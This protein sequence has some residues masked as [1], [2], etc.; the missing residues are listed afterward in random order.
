MRQAI[1]DYLFANKASLKGLTLSDNL[2]WVD[3]TAPLYLQNKKY[4]YVDVDQV[5]QE[6][7][8][9]TLKSSGFVDEITTVTVYFAIDAKLLLPNYE[10]LVSVIKTARLTQDI[11]G[12]IHRLCQVTAEYSGDN[13]VTK[14]DFSFRKMLTNQ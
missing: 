3:N 10:D 11:D 9:D 2:P 4:I 8:I 7:L 14:F 6:T 12:V 13:L 5:Q 1:Y